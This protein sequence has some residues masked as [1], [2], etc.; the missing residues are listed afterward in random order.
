MDI[1]RKIVISNKY[2]RF[3]KVLILSEFKFVEAASLYKSLYPECHPISATTL[4][5]LFI[6]IFLHYTQFSIHIIIKLFFFRF[7]RKIFNMAV[8]PQ[9]RR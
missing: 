4:K 7:Y 6:I 5:R 9:R 3:L 2:R 1:D 8:L